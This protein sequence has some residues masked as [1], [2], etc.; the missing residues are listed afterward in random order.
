MNSYHISEFSDEFLSSVRVLT[1]SDLKILEEG[2]NSKINNM[3]KEVTK[4]QN[5]IFKDLGTIYQ[6]T[7]KGIREQIN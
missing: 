6:N 7:V 2:F 1:N 4:S 5:Q 3:H